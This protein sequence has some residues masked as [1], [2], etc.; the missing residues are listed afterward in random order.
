MNRL[1]HR[2]ARRRG[3]TTAQWVVVAAVI[4]LAIVAAVRNVG[5]NSSS[6]LNTTSGNIGNPST[7]PARFGS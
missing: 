2:L 3:V 4:T 7:L 5:L 6:S 1:R